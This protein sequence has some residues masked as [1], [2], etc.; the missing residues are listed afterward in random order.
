MLQ[1]LGQLTAVDQTQAIKDKSGKIDMR[2]TTRKKYELHFPN[3]FYSSSLNGWFCKVCT[4][5]APLGVQERSFIEIPGGFGNHPTDRSSL[6]LYSKRHQQSVLNKQAFNE[7]C[8]KNMDVYKLLV[9]DSHANQVDQSNQNR[10][11]MKRFFRITHFM[12]MK[13]WGYTHNFQDVVKL[14]SECGGNEVK[15]HLTSSPKNAIFTSPNILASLSALL[16][17]IKLPIL[18]SLRE[19]HFTFFG[20]EIQD[21]TSVDQM[22]V[23]AT[24]EYNG[25][26]TKHFVGIYPLSKVVGALL[27]AANI[28]KSLEKYFQNQSA[29]LMRARFSCMDTTVNSGE[30][31]GLKRYLK[32]TIPHLILVGCGNHK[33]TL[34]FMHLLNR[35]PSVLETD[36]FLESLWKFFKYRPLAKNLLE[37]SADLYDEN[38]VVPVAP[39]VTRWTANERACKSVIKDYCQFI[40]LLTTCYNERQ[41]PEALGLTVHSCK[42]M[43]VATILMLIEVFDC[44]GPLGFLLQKGNGTLCLADIPTY[45]ERLR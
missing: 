19:N 28:M 13:N 25:V 29:D 24:F 35:F 18:A 5:F 38:V 15:T 21:I 37:E 32:N 26:I 9:E 12:I 17:T 4:N 45:V 39:C 22:A 27:S 7:L 6:Y 2:F 11:V 30:R 31:D 44:T 20:D 40:S 3:F 14:V 34:C 1:V 42:P 43:I 8:T 36:V 10:F 16:M 23:Y 33:L 41:E